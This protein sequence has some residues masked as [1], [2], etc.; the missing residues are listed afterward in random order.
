VS[1]GIKLV[2]AG[3]L[4]IIIASAAAFGTTE[5]LQWPFDP[6]EAVVAKDQSR[7][8]SGDDASAYADYGTMLIQLTQAARPQAPTDVAPRPAMSPMHGGRWNAPPGPPPIPFK[9]GFHPPGPMI[10]APPPSGGPLLAGVAPDRD[11]CEEDI[12]R[13]VALMA[14]LKSKLR[15]LGPQ[16]AAWQK[17]MVAADPI[18]DEIYRACTT[19]P[20]RLDGPPKRSALIDLAQKQLALRVALVNAIAGPAHHLYDMLSP[21][22]RAIFDTP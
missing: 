20:R 2:I 13:S 12:A 19:L 3:G 22:Q 8:A 5:R 4:V 14:Y 17:L 6:P 21:E 10:G 1:S 11:A 18:V 16:Q 7:V 15:L 9:L